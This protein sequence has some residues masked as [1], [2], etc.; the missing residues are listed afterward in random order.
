VTGSPLPD[1]RAFVWRCAA[2]FVVAAA[3]TVY[4]CATMDG[5]VSMPGGWTMSMAFMRMPGQTWLGAAAVFELVWVVMMAAMMVPV[6]VI[7]LLPYRRS[8]RQR[9]ISPGRSTALVAAGYAAVWAACGAVAYVLGTMSAF[10]TMSAPTLS[11]LVPVATGIVVL[12]AGGYQL[13]RWKARQLDCCHAFPADAHAWHEGSDAWRA[14]LR[15]GLTCVA[16]CAG[17]MLVLLALGVM[18]IGV[19]VAVTAAITFERVAGRPWR[20]AAIVGA[21]TI[22]AGCVIVVRA[23]GASLP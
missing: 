4:S 19:M 14:G 2:A 11:K 22:A 10:A 5:G 12:L 1:D 8:L 16:C 23:T 18:N 13:T 6:L 20:A 17:L 9:G 15:L 3:S 21:V 7:A